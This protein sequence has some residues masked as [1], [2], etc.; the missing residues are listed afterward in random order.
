MKRE[1]VVLIAAAMGLSACGGG[2]SDTTTSN[3]NS[4]GEVLSSL[5]TG[6]A[7]PSEISAVPADSGSGA[8]SFVNGFA[9]RLHALAR[10]VAVADLPAGSDYQKA[11]TRKFVEERSLEQ[12]DIIEQVMDA[13]QQTNYAD[14]DNI[15][16][17]PYKAMIAWEDE[18]NGIDIK[19]LQPWVIDSRMIVIDG[20]DVN[21]VLAWIEEPDF[22]NPG[23][24]LVIKAEFKVYQAAT[25]NADGSYAD[26]GEWD[27]NVKF[28]DTGTDF[29]AATARIVDGQTVL[30][31]NESQQRNEQGQTMTFA[32]KAVMYRA[33]SQGYGKVQYPDM[34]CNGGGGCTQV[35]K[36]VNYAYNADYLA[37][38]EVDDG[39]AGAV[40]YKDRNGQTDFTHRYGLFYA[41]ADAGNGI[42]AGDSVQ[43]HKAFGFPVRYTDDNGVTQHA[44][45]GAWQGRHQLWA[46]GGSLAAGTLVTREDRG[47]N[48]TAETYTVSAPFAG[49]LTKRTLVQGDVTDILD[50]AVETF[51]NKHFNIAYNGGS[52]QGCDGWV[53]M[54]GPTCRDMGGADIGFTTFD[55]F[56]SLMMSEGDRKRV[57]I[58]RWDQ[59]LN[60]SDGGMVDYVYLS[61]NGVTAGFYEATRD[62]QTGMP[63]P[64]QTDTPASFTNGDMLNINIG[65]SIYIQYVGDY[66]GPTTTTGWVQKTLQD[67]DQQTWTPTFAEGGDSAFTPEP[68]RDY[69]INNKGA[70]YVVRRK[71]NNN[72]IAAGDYEVMAELQS[73]A[74]P[75]NYNTIMPAGA[76]YLRAPWRPDVRYQFVTSGEN[77]L[78]LVVQGVDG[79]NSTLNV[80]AVVTS[81]EWGLRAYS[82]NG[83]P[84]DYSDDAPLMADGSPVTVDEWGMPTD[85]DQRPVEFNWEYSE[86][87]G[88]WGTQQYLMEGGS[89]VLLSDPI[90]LQ[91]ITVAN[92]AGVDKNLSLQFDGW[93]HGL[94][95][96]YHELSKNGWT[97]NQNIANKVI[98][99][100]EATL[101]TDTN[102]VE[103]YVKPLEVSVFLNAVADPGAGAP[104]I[105]QADAVSLD[106][107]MPTFVE[108]NMGAL[109]SNT[110][111]K[112]SEGK[113]VE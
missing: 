21:R 99:I 4:D 16:A 48:D 40:T 86:D 110:E 45:Y 5:V 54:S 35:T 111:I 68:G 63:T 102:G 93:M 22:D 94:P 108:H 28:N 79:P 41:N 82:D 61:G 107:G 9:S 87:E 81:G 80:G 56:N 1:L 39:V 70:N 89:Y 91:P 52:W 18:Q 69:Y 105:D 32:T 12:F 97:M 75:V 23:Q 84:N 95:D 43:K 88:G 90:Q 104:D 44:Y 10:A 62:D 27:L 11:S 51:V 49:T 3:T 65:G 50:M 106:T 113:A 42:A 2:S 25:Q 85:P 64:V 14:Q 100:P 37:L 76:D 109:P 112:Y 15:N 66:D 26:Y 47:P 20:R 46:Q 78:K 72:S 29:F 7:L 30:K 24:T 53:D 67:F 92:G 34:N 58:S 83:T 60:G 19:Q 77:F 31:I 57:N 101:V 71:N 36:A 33:G 8:A 74:N 59:T 6:Y 73:A 98:N 38:Q 13:L 55:D 96:L 17:G 103:Y